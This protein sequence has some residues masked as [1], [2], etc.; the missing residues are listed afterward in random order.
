MKNIGKIVQLLQKMLVGS[1]VNMLQYGYRKA[2]P[3]VKAKVAFN[4]NGGVLL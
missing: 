4:F 2:D 1:A 3:K